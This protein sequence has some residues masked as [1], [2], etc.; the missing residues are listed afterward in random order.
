MSWQFKKNDLH[1]RNFC[2]AKPKNF[3]VFTC[4]YTHVGKFCAVFGDFCMKLYGVDSSEAMEQRSEAIKRY[5][6]A[7]SLQ[8]KK[9][10]KYFIASSLLYNFLHS[11]K[12]F[13][14]VTF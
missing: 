3:V 14:A 8:L 4:T 13:I 10:I 11:V 7:P 1:L 12:P 5:K 2:K 9:S 6:N